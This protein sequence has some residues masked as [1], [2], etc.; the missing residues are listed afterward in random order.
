LSFSFFVECDCLLD[1]QMTSELIA[2]TGFVDGASHHTLNLA[3]AAWV[4]YELSGQLLSSGSTCLGP[5]TN[6]IAEY[7]A[8]IK[9]LL[10]VISHGIQHMVV[11]LDSQ[12]VVLQLNGQYQVHD[13]FLLRKYLRVKLLERQFHFIT[14]VHIPRSENRLANSLA[15]FALD[16]HITHFPSR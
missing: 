5:S 11:R 12:L 2:Y 1:L 16:W 7:S 6:N 13:S 8:I 4:I 9:L 14:Y 3:S 15:N 10:D